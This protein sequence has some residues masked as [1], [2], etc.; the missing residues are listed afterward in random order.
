MSA[1]PV[2]ATFAGFSLRNFTVNEDMSQETVAFSA[3]VYDEAAE[4]ADCL[5]VLTNDG[6]GG[7]DRFVPVSGEAGARWRRASE[8]FTPIP[9]VGAQNGYTGEWGLSD[10]LSTLS[11][12][13][14]D[15]MADCP[16]SDMRVIV[17]GPNKIVANNEVEIVSTTG[18]RKSMS[19]TARWRFGGECAEDYGT[20][21]FALHDPKTG[22]VEVYVADGER[23]PSRA[24]EEEISVC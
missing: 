19:A 24:K 15:V 6:H 16:A 2:V 8:E 10:A 14:Y 13:M 3:Q 7:M 20:V 17:G 4:P 1:V 9:W 5:G 23:S 12:A 21:T 22:S 11:I 18:A